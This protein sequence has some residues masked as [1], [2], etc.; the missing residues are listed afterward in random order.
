MGPPPAA[1]MRV[2]LDTNT[3]VSALL[4]TGTAS[5]LVPHWQ[6]QRISLLL[7]G[8]MLEEYLRVLAYQKFKLTAEDVRAL[9]EEQLLP[10]AETV[11]ARRRLRP[12]LPDRD[13]WKFVDC[14]VAGRAAYLITGERELRTLGS[15]RTVTILSVGEFLSHLRQ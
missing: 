2:V 9:L 8:A 11:R 6:A 1:V 5:A 3:V 7:S 14:A 10:F 13:D 12:P 15:Y 4:F